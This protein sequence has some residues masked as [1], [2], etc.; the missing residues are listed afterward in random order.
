MLEVQVSW[1]SITVKGAH[2]LEV[3]VSWFS[4]TVKGATHAGS[5]SLM[6]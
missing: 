6:V 4:T 1:F 5:P 2:M 3:Q